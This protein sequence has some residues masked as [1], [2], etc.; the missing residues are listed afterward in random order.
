M[1]GSPFYHSLLKKY[2]IVFGTLFNN[3][4][5]ERTDDNNNVLER[6]RVPLAYGPREKHLA[7]V[8]TNLGSDIPVATRLPRMGF[9]MTSIMSAPQRKLNTLN[10]YQK[11]VPGNRAK[12]YMPVPYDITFQLS[13]MAKTMEDGTRILEQIIPYFTPEF[14]VSA[15][16]IETLDDITD[17]PIVLNSISPEDTYDTDFETRRMI[18]F[19]LDFTMKVLFWGPVSQSKIIK[20][21]EVNFNDEDLPDPYSSITIQP[22]LTAN[23]QPTTDI[24]QTIPFTDIDVDDNWDYIIR[25]E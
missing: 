13:I 24:T 4:S 19:N 1:L 9:D 12:A 21:V 14:T 8:E 3:I 2:I 20:F 11:N 18:M 15:K 22:G 10:K 25:I 16:M 6:M 5:I 23:G 7:R 17:I